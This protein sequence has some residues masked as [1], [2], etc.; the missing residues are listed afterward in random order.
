[1]VDHLISKADVKN[2]VEYKKKSIVP[3]VPGHEKIEII[4]HINERWL[5]YKEVVTED[6]EKK[7][8]N[9]RKHARK[10]SLAEKKDYSISEH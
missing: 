10:C 5:N 2:K 3:E 1:M 8:E 7:F 9:K 4:K 6:D